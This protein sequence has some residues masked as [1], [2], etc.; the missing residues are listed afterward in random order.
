[1]SGN[2]LRKELILL[3]IISLILLQNCPINGES[4][5]SHIGEF[6]VHKNNDYDGNK[7]DTTGSSFQY[8]IITSQYLRS[9]FE[10]YIEDH[11]SKYISSRLFTLEEDILPVSDYW[12][13]GTWGDNNPDNMYVENPIPAEHCKL[14]NDTP[15]KI[16]NFI[17]FTVHELGTE[18]VLL[19][20]DVEIIPARKLW[21]YMPQW[22]KGD[23]NVSVE[24]NITSDVYYTSLYGNWNDDFDSRFG[25]PE[26]NSTR[27]E[28]EFWTNVYVGRAPVNT[29]PEASAF[30]SKVI[31]YESS[32]NRPNTITLHQSGINHENDPDSTVIP[33][34]CAEHVINAGGFEI[35]KLYAN[36]SSINKE[37]WKNTFQD[38]RLI[39]LHVGNGAETYYQLDNINFLIP[40]IWDTDDT[41]KMTNEK[42]Y[43]IHFS[44]ACN[45][46]NFS[47]SDCLA[48]KFLTTINGG[49]ACA[50]IFN[51]NYG[52]TS[53]NNAHK[54][55]GE[56]I[57]QMFVQIFDEGTE[58]IGKIV[59]KAKESFLIQNL[60]FFKNPPYRWCYYVINLLGDPEM[61]VLSTEREDNIPD[62]LWV[63][64]DYNSTTPGWNITRFD[65]IQEA[66]DRINAT[67]TVVVLPGVYYENL[68]INKPLALK[69]GGKESTVVDGLFTGD[70]VRVEADNVE[71]SGLTIRNSGDEPIPITNSGIKIDAR[72]NIKVTYC[73][74]SYNKVGILVR[75][76][77]SDILIDNNLI[78]NNNVDGISIFR[79]K[80]I[81][82]SN[83]NIYNQK[84]SGIYLGLSSRNQIYNNSIK[85]N[86]D[87]IILYT[88]KNNLITYNNISFN[89]IDDKY[90]LL[91]GCG[92]LQ[93][94]H[95]TLNKIWENDFYRNERYGIF[96]RLMS[97][98]NTVFWNNFI[99]N[100]VSHVFFEF[101]FRS[102]YMGGYGEGNYWDNWVGLP[103][104]NWTRMPYM[105]WG[106]WGPI[107][108]SHFD[109]V[110]LTT[111]RIHYY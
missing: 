26:E 91:T 49:G 6:V 18:Y 46:S 55:S 42:F 83:N 12:V 40:K 60:S 44:I 85:F 8:V 20:G 30:I 35:E 15:A 13:N 89:K 79:S 53:Y 63:D 92:I 64:D 28:A 61:L 98:L 67:G 33:E 10:R 5:D 71:I 25:E 2:F 24:K 70:V 9:D 95:S 19:G 14:F 29:G 99:G 66:L 17:R 45:S 96:L 16:R 110:P 37:V 32:K 7:M 75:N 43:P 68:I 93:T 80:S 77:S 76:S 52:V 90:P 34:K 56:F 41:D 108:V 102:S 100:K 94:Y 81:R 54:Y 4:T 78:T 97:N 111:K 57:E 73:N 47:Q 86:S 88:S 109:W 103:P 84:E 74:I 22:W 105:I 48:E 104:A 3:T 31:K 50:C 51:T 101:C 87:G 36:S 23:V 106:R 39:V 1:M 38:G 72:K 69:G 59:Q 107:P 58:H 65:I 27:D 11:K 62:R 82:I 21:A